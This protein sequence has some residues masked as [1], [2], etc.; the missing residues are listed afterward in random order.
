MSKIKI[1]FCQET[2]SSGGVEKTKLSVAK[3]LGQQKYE[4]KLVCTFA[5]GPLINEFTDLGIEVIAIGQ[6]KNLF[7]MAQYLK[8]LK[9]IKRFN[10][11]IIHGAVFEGVTM[12][13]VA[14]FFGRVPIIIAEETSDPQ[15]R[16]EKASLLLRCLTSLADKIVAISP[17]V[18][19]YLALKAKIPA[20]KIQVID[21]G[22]D[23][24]RN[25]SEEELFSIKSLYHI[26]YNDIVIGSVGRL[27]NDHKRFTDLILAF[28]TLVENRNVKLLIVGGGKDEQLL[29]DLVTCL[30]ICN[31][32]VF[33]GYQSDTAPF[34]R[35]MDIFCLASQ[36][37]G[38]GLVVA[39]AMLNK[40]PVIVTKV[41]GMKNIVLPNITGLL[42]PPLQ[43]E[44]LAEGL[45][46]LLR[47]PDLRGEMGEAGY[48]RAIANYT[49]EVYGRKVEK[50]YLDLIDIKK[51]Q[52]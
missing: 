29:K 52:L 6:F 31:Q 32:V 18:A 9:I 28:S 34:Y 7:H 43:P 15:N 44:M 30:G 46:K 16:S 26:Q 50:M 23:L 3:Y 14:G 35:I 51:I 2:L 40:L 17:D 27:D 5:E 21:N 42:V 22:V 49:A 38:F 39:E 41:G 47:N 8:L 24:P 33:A 45:E 10:P 4:I 37:E 25:V 12:A 48:K 1:L 19:K 13:C 11:H 20:G 36:R